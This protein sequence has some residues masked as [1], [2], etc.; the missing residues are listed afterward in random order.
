MSCVVNLMTSGF[1]YTSQSAF[2]FLI[3]AVCRQNPLSSKSTAQRSHLVHF[4]YCHY[5]IEYLMRD[6][7][8]YHCLR[9]VRSRD[10][11]IGKHLPGF[12]VFRTR[13]HGRSDPEPSRV[14]I[15]STFVEIV[16]FDN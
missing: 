16:P 12:S 3:S 10:R 1:L 5:V 14:P 2:S 11:G 6:M 7:M 15:Q 13:V 9:V 8:D 4:G